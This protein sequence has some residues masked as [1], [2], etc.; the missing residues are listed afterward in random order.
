M[1][2]TDR[3]ANW[4][5]AP[6]LAVAAA[7]VSLCGCASYAPVPLGPEAAATLAEPAPGAL[8]SAVANIR[9]PSLRP[10][11]ID[12]GKPLSPEA[13]GLIAVAA[14]PD[15]KAA[16][17]KAKVAEAQAFSAGL[18]PD[19]VIAL[20]YD[21]ILSGPD[22][23]DPIVGQLALD[24]AALR[25]LA[26][27]RAAGRAA[28]EQARFDLAW[29]EWQVAGQARLLAYRIASLERI[30]AIDQQS[31]D[32]AD[33]LMH[34]VLA[35]AARGDIRAEEVQA[36]RIAAAEAGDRARQAERDLG[37]ARQDLNRILGLAPDARLAIAAG[38]ALA[39]TA[40]AEALFAE[41]RAQRLDLRALEAGYD[42]QEALTR[43]AVLDQFPS[44]QLTITRQADTTPNQLLG[45]QVSFTPPL[46]N[47]NRGGIAVAQATREQLRAEYAARLFA[48]RAEIAQL[49]DGLR[50]ARRQRAEAEG[51]V[52]PLGRIA[53]ALDHAAEHGDVARAAAEAARQ[54]AADKALAMAMLD[55]SIAEQSVA[56]DIAVGGAW[57]Q[58][59][60]AEGSRP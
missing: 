30:S 34:T 31:R 21:H 51:Q 12:L 56:L 19:P 44:L 59:S 28:L 55:Q 3:K 39:A 53:D 7:C 58:D 50:I 26:A 13:L 17:A 2:D 15:L 18:L 5:C 1:R 14:D 48:T 24:L 52:V 33:S 16:R 27:T 38:P 43:K 11:E 8:A 36:R 40:S 45:P 29:Q 47:R 37:A 23:A 46:W 6:W 22:P 41:A 49:V 10:V 57:R 42:S 60:A 54:G 20:G 4:P 9:H 25:D 32:R 35:A